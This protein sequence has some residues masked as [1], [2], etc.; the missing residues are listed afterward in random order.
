M[1]GRTRRGR[2]YS[3]LSDHAGAV[4]DVDADEA[5]MQQ[6]EVV[7]ALRSGELRSS[8]LVNIDGVWT[9]LLDSPPFGEVAETRA[10]RD[11]LWQHRRSIFFA[12]VGLLLSLAVAAA[13]GLRMFGR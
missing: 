2:E 5:V 12:A 9:T 6:A 4:Y 10:G 3:T 13:F 1:S 7:A 11:R 8:D